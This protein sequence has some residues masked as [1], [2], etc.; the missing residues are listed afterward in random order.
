[1]APGG[2]VSKEATGIGDG[3]QLKRNDT[4]RDAGDDPVAVV[5]NKTPDAVETDGKAATDSEAP[6]SPTTVIRT[7]RHKEAVRRVVVWLLFGA[8]FGLMPLFAV[9]LKESFSPDGFSMEELLKN[10]DLFI[11]SA[12]LA[13]GA[14]GELLAAAS[15]GAM[16]FY[17][18]I[19]S[20]FSCLATFAGDTIAYVVAST[21]SP[22]EVAT[23]SLWF[24]PL[25][26]LASGL[27]VGTAAYS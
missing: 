9:T 20:G 19:F 13:A 15:R 27:C 18:A 14:L 6:D 16:N 8:I 2:E 4:A 24:F 5:A 12:V 7:K 25:T 3:A 1:M 21:A 10:G 17:F 22:A 26:L 23:A 11:V